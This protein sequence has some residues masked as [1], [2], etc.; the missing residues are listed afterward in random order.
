M[1]EVLI[2]D[3]S[4]SRVVYSGDWQVGTVVSPISNEYNSTFHQSAG[5]GDKLSLT[6]YGRYS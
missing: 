1:S 4:D 3:D 6:F 2:I 5:A